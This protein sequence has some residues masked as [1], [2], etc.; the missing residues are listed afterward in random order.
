MAAPA[1]ADDSFP[2][3]VSAVSPGWSSVSTTR[4]S[5]SGAAPAPTDRFGASCFCLS[6]WSSTKSMKDTDASGMSATFRSASS[7]VSRT[8]TGSSVGPAASGAS[9]STFSAAAAAAARAAVGSSP[10]DAAMAVAASAPANSA[11]SPCLSSFGVSS[12][13]SSAA[14]ADATTQSGS[15]DSPLIRAPPLPPLPATAAGTAPGSSMRSS[16]VSKTTTSAVLLTTAL[17][18][19]SSSI[20]SSS[21]ASK[22][23]APAAASSS[24][25]TPCSS[26]PSLSSL[27]PAAVA[28]GLLPPSSSP[29][30][31]SSRGSPSLCLRGSSG[32]A[33]AFILAVTSSTSSLRER[34]RSGIFPMRLSRYGAYLS[35]MS[36]K[37]L[38]AVSIC[39]SILDTLSMSYSSLCTA[40]SSSVNVRLGLASADGSAG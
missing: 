31:F 14:S 24:S 15:P 10:P 20:S 11:S 1:H 22:V 27:P 18:G 3:A 30:R 8:T 35:S 4:G 36:T 9:P 37:S 6:P 29:S 5:A 21:L 17:S 34:S 25:S 7:W 28:S 32:G 33:L 39:L 12:I 19:A 13:K 26:A 16:S 2:A 23:P 38:R 40:F